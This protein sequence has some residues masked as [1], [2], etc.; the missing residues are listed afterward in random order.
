MAVKLTEILV[1]P[2]THH[3]VGYTHVP[4][5]LLQM[6]E[7]F[8]YEAM[9]LCERDGHDSSASAFRWTVEASQPL[10]RFLRRA[11]A[12]DIERLQALVARKRMSV[13]A[14]DAIVFPWDRWVYT[15]QGF[16]IH[17][18]LKVAGD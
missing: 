3:D 13:T 5:T 2:H 8:I 10:P 6:H 18:E 11:S 7:H 4:E 9:A 17:P 15:G 12:H 16:E 1:V 14:N